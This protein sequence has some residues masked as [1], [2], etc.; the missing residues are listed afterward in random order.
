MRIYLLVVAYLGRGTYLQ[1]WHE[2]R[3]GDTALNIE[4]AQ[5]VSTVPT[6]CQKQALNGAYNIPKGTDKPKIIRYKKNTEIMRKTINYTKKKNNT[7]ERI[8]SIPVYRLRFDKNYLP[9]NLF[10]KRMRYATIIS[11]VAERVFR[12]E[13]AFISRV[14]YLVH[15]NPM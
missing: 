9:M 2:A 10:Q 11:Y 1:L 12:Y 6:Q 4:D 14:Q 7:S 5:R 3:K 13:W 8:D 15:Q